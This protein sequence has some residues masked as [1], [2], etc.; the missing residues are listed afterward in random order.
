MRSTLAPVPPL[1]EVTVPLNRFIPPGTRHYFNG[2]PDRPYRRRRF[3]FNGH[4]QFMPLVRAFLDTCAARRDGDYRY[5]F[6]LLGSELA[7]NAIRHS[8]SGGPGG[9]FTLL[10]ERSA[11]GIT[12]TCRDGG[13]ADTGRWDAR[14]RSYLSPRPGALSP[15]T[16]CGRG[17]ALVERLASEWGDN[18]VP[19]YRQV[20]FFLAYD[21]AGSAWRTARP[22]PRTSSASPESSASASA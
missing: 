20:W 6:T 11:A 13:R 19:D 7:T 9:V 8:R 21:L 18:G 2:S 1:P 3:D 10:A 22:A 12:L 14:A 15:D 17:L 4:P 5:L 16:E